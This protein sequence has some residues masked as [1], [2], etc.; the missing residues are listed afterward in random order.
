M[1]CPKCKSTN[2][3]KQGYVGARQRY[4]CKS[5]GYLYSVEYRGK[6][7]KMKQ[8]ALKLYLEGMGYRGIGRFLKVS[9][10]SVMN[11]I[12]KFGEEADKT[13]EL[14]T[15][16][17]IIEMDELHTY[18]GSKKTTNGFGRRS[19]D[20]RKNLLASKSVTGELKQVVNCT[21]K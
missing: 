20:L 14:I 10:V 12:R 7:M 2:Y 18:I 21:N 1:D 5:C 15:P 8:D 11:W 9:A 4:K 17:P 16:A 13:V 3:M 6:P 19:T